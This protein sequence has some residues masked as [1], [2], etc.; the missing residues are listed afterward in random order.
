MLNWS[1]Y[2]KIDLP[3][4]IVEQEKSKLNRTIEAITIRESRRLHRSICEAP[5]Q[6][7]VSL[8]GEQS[9]KN[10]KFEHSYSLRIL[11]TNLNNYPYELM[12]IC[13]Q[14]LPYPAIVGINEKASC[15]LPFNLNIHYFST[16]RK[17][18]TTIFLVETP[19]DFRELL[20]EFLSTKII[21]QTISEWH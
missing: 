15:E 4:E 10:I 9:I 3:V 6:A 19:E 20:S 5:I 1:F 8:I 14:V 7:N 13:H 16:D 2:G 18:S 11:I 21:R 12:S 17:K